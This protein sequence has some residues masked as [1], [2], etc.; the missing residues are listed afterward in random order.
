MW[1]ASDYGTVWWTRVHGPARLRRTLAEWAG[2][3]GCIL[4]HHRA[5]LPWADTL[6]AQVQTEIQNRD[7]RRYIL[8]VEDRTGLGPAG[9]SW[10]LETFAPAC[11]GD[12]LS[13]MTLSRFLAGRRAL[14]GKM[15]WICGMDEAEQERWVE[16]LAEFAAGPE[17][18]ECILILETTGR[19]PLRKKKMRTLEAEEFIRPFDR[20]QLCTMAVGEGSESSLRKDYLAS[21]CVELA[22]EDPERLPE[23]LA[24]REE[25]L[26]DPVGTA[27]QGLGLPPAQG[28]HAIRRAQ[29]QLLL[30]LLEDVR[31]ALLER[32]AGAC[33]KLLPFEDEFHNRCGDLYQMEL[34]HLLYFWGKGTLFLPPEEAGRVRLAQEARNKLLHE[35]RAL[36]FPLLCRVL[37]LTEELET[38]KSGR[39]R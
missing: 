38:E 13:A 6:R 2:E 14:A 37:E 19:R 9:E 33:R 29:L 35:M 1:S 21:L 22:G 12:F 36:D 26:R 39:D 27:Q 8:P 25:L 23:L 15:V 20:K 16:R 11:A 30:P 31:V 18:K 34:R 24:R 4:F 32:N 17:A 28:T 3:G 10:F 5:P 7:G